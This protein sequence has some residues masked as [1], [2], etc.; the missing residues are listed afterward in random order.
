LLLGIEAV[1]IRRSDL[2]GGEACNHGC[3]GAGYRGIVVSRLPAPR[4]GAS[5]LGV[6]GTIVL[7]SVLW[8]A[9]HQQYNWLASLHLPDGADF[10]WVRQAQRQHNADDRS[11]CSQQSG[12]HG[13]RAVQIEWLS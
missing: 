4:L 2:S 8:A 9:L 3:P 6:S 1:K 11:A 13:P 7:T 5:W 12:R 10:G